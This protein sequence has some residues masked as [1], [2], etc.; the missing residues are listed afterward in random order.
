TDF[1]KILGEIT[2]FGGADSPAGGLQR[3]RNMVEVLDL[4]EK[5]RAL[6]SGGNLVGLKRLNLLR[7]GFDGVALRVAVRLGMRGFDHADVV[8]EKRHA[9]G[10]AERSGL[11]QIADFR[12]GAVPVVRETF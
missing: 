7:A 2:D 9:A 4:R 8:E 11:E 6:L 1:D 12:R 3:L 10:L 5:T